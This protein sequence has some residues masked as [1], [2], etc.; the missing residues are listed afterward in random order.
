MTVNLSYT[1]AK[2]GEILYIFK[3][4]S[5]TLKIFVLN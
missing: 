3:N 2:Y 5:T 4:N 1:L